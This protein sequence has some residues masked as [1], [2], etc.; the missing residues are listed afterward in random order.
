V[1]FLVFVMIVEGWFVGRKV[2]RLAAQRFPGESTQG[3]ILYTIM[4]GVS[5]R[6]MRIPRPRVNRGDKV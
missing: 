4:R 6:R 3:V 2:K 5:L 1:I